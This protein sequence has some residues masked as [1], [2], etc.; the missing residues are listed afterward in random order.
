[1]LE[2]LCDEGEGL[3]GV[4]AAEVVDLGEDVAVV[5]GEQLVEKEGGVV[6]VGLAETGCMAAHLLRV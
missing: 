5:E 4:V 6:A 1:V 3:L 2:Y